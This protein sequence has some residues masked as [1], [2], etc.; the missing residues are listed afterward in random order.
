VKFANKTPLI[1]LE[2][3]KNLIDAGWSK[4]KGPRNLGIT[5]SISIPLMFINSIMS[6]LV[7]IP[8]YNQFT[9]ILDYNP[10][11]LLYKW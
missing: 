2:L 1:D 8:L 3:S 9:S 10:F 7:M 5:I 11:L 4:I 6:M